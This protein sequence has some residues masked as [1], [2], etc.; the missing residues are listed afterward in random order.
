MKTLP[1]KSAYVLSIIYEK[2]CTIPDIEKRVKEDRFRIFFEE[3]G[4]SM[5]QIIHYLEIN[6]CIEERRRI[7]NKHRNMDQSFIKEYEITR[8]GMIAIENS[9]AIYLKTIKYSNIGLQN[10]SGTVVVGEK[11]RDTKV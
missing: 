1:P 9:V 6:D 3:R 10:A 7:E 2:P 11:P 5:R 8:L 4:S